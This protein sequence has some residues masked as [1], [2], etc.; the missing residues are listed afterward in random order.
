MEQ[1]II[2]LLQ[3]DKYA[4]K[5]AALEAEL[6]RIDEDLHSSSEKDRL[7]AAR[8]LNRL[9][10]AEL[11][12]MLLSVRNHFLSP[13]FRDLLDPVI[14]TAD[15]RTRAILLHTMRNA[16]ERYIVHPMWGDLRRE[17]DGS[18]W[19]AWI[20][21]TGETFIENSDLPIRGEAAYLLAL[22]GDPRGWETYLEIVPKRSALLG[23]LEL[24]IL[25]CPDSRTPAMVDSILALADETERRHPGQAYTAQSIRD[26]LRVRFG[27]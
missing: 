20:L 3:S 1:Q 22:S 16:Y 17:D 4:R 24:A 8:A 9:A 27:D 26:A 15:A 6:A 23:Q 21:S 10:R 11:S 19:D 12:W 13:A 14:D 7:H 5:A 25:L 2:S 18:W